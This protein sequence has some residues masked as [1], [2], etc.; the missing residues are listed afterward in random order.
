LRNQNFKNH[1]FSVA[2]PGRALSAATPLSDLIL[3]FFLIISLWMYVFLYR[4]HP[5]LARFSLYL[6]TFLRSSYF[7]FVR[8]LLQKFLDPPLELLT[9]LRLIIRNIDNSLTLHIL[10]MKKYFYSFWLE[11]NMTSTRH[12]HDIKLRYCAAIII[13]KWKSVI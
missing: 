9:Y 10:T 1:G 13:M 8:T 6:A 2:D 7:C 3:S 4:P 11:I 5:L 12:R